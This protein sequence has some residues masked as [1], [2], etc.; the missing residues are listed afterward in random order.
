MKKISLSLLLV[1]G[2]CLTLYPCQMQESLDGRWRAVWETSG[3]DVPLPLF[4][5]I[6]ASGE[7]QAEVH[8]GF[9]VIRFDRV[10]KKE[11]HIDFFIDR[12]ECVISVDLAEDGKS[13]KGTWSKQ[14]GRPNQTPFTAEKG[15]EERFPADMYKPLEG[16]APVQDISGRWRLRF[17]GDEWD[18]VGIFKQDGENVEGT[19]RAI[20]G[21]FHFLKGVYRN[22]LLLVSYFNGS[23]VFLF[24]AEMDKDGKLHGYWARGP[25]KP[26]PWTAVKDEEADLVDCYSLTKLSN[27]EGLFRFKYPLAE[28]PDRMISNSDPEYQG[29]PLL[30]GITMNGCPN[31]HDSAELL[32]ELYNQYHERG[33]NIVCIHTELM[34]DIPRIQSR[35]AAFKKAHG[36]KF[37]IVF[38][39]AKTKKEFNKE[40]SD[41]ERFIAWPTVIFIG[42]DGKVDT[43]HT[44]FDSKATGVYYKKLV[45][46]YRAIIERL[47]KRE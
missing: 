5:K 47:L 46:K 15:N 13:M 40:I 28:D 30:V 35:I 25:K 17:E 41:L 8:N 3:G 9:E 42:R 2:F 16:K 27:K 19:I 32:S 11:N 45:K 34:K 43:T 22:G 1:L 26:Y 6:D 20:D 39:T 23:W 14:T 7:I 38:S 29:K 44:G 24:R 31:A 18:S 10:E 4:I 33:L 37:P 21:D 12:Y 36:I